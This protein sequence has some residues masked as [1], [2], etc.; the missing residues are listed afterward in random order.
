MDRQERIKG[1]IAPQLSGFT[2]RTVR[3]PIYK[4]RFDF[5]GIG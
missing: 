3:A 5:F 2:H 4:K 1:K